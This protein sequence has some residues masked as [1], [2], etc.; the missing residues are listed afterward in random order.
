MHPSEATVTPHGLSRPT[1]GCACACL[2]G[3]RGG[4]LSLSAYSL[5]IHGPGYGRH[6]GRAVIVTGAVVVVVTVVV[7][8]TVATVVAVAVT[9]Y[10][11]VSIVSTSL[12]MDHLSYSN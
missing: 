11:C 7:T 9:D 3:L 2:R 5:S 6:W 10:V 8:L 12:F 1:S 4:S